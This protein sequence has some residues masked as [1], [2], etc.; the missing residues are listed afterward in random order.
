MKKQA[1][2]KVSKANSAYT[3]ADC[4]RIWNIFVQHYGFIIDLGRQSYNTIC[5]LQ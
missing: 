3:F 4:V 1:E 2:S 5:Q